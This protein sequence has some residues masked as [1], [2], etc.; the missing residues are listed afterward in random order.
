MN[1]GNKKK[2][3]STRNQI[4]SLLKERFEIEKRTSLFVISTGHFYGM[5]N[6]V[7]NNVRELEEYKQESI[8]SLLEEA[9]QLGWDFG[10][11][12]NPILSH[13]NSNTLFEWRR[14]KRDG[15]ILP[16]YATSELWPLLSANKGVTKRVCEPNTEAKAKQIVL[17]DIAE[18]FARHDEIYS[19]K[20]TGRL[21]GWDGFLIIPLQYSIP[22][23]IAIFE[24]HNTYKTRDNHY[25]HG[26]TVNRYKWEAMLHQHRIG[27][28]PILVLNALD[29][30]RWAD[31]SKIHP[32]DITVGIS[33]TSEY[34]C[35][36][37]ESFVNI[38]Y[39]AFDILETII[40]TV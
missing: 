23:P 33:D 12:W 28:C 39:W 30:T 6:M 8:D 40:E 32:S 17:K 24:I 34:Y 31:V 7:M 37:N 26:V 10:D 35:Q 25:L 29:V 27:V 15:I 5:M 19:V 18:I 3:P 36:H 21:C 38:K 13:I 1:F 22:K 20:E 9:F 2:N 16:S 11:D 4:E 14:G